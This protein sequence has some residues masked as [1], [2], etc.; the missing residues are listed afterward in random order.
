MSKTRKIVWIGM[1]SAFAYVLMLLDFSVA[2]FIPSFIKMDFSEVP[3]LIASFAIGPVSGV[4]V[5]LIK[6]LVHL[7]VTS[8]GGVGELSN[9]LLGASFAFTAGMIYKR[10]KGIKSALI[11]S[12]AG[13]AAMAIVSFPVNLYITYPFYSKLMPID[14]IIGAYG[15]I[16]KGIDSLWEALLYVS[17]PFNFIFKGLGNC[18]LTF[19]VY[20][21]ISPLIKKA[22]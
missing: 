4:I 21:R 19:L 20:K 6:N 13:A 15:A 22:K 5:C 8:T 18:A 16:W 7:T 2:F 14:A 9:F 10:K 1:L 11:A 3:A 12:L 17:T